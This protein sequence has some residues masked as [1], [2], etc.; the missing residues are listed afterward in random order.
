VV[1]T[2]TGDFLFGLA[3][4]YAAGLSLVACAEG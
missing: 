1:Y 2:R 4:A 3:L